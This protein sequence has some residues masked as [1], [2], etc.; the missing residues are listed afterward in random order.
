MRSSAKEAFRLEGPG[1]ARLL[2]RNLIAQLRGAFCG[3]DEAN[4]AKRSTLAAFLIR[5]MSAGIA[6]ISQILLARLMGPFEYGIFALVWVCVVIAGNLS[7]FGMQMAVIR[8]LPEYLKAGDIARLKGLLSA[9]RRFIALTSTT[10]A[11]LAGALI[12]L[13]S[14]WMQSYYV[15]PFLIGAF[16]LPMISMGDSVE[17]V[18]R[19][20]G[21]AIRA[22]MPTYIIR[23]M[24]L[25]IFML[26]AWFLGLDINGTNAL[27]CAVLATYVTTIGQLLVIG[28]LVNKTYR[29]DEA[30]KIELSKWIVVAL[31]M[32][33]VEGFFFLLV[34]ADVL[35]IGMQMNPD[36]VALYYATVKTLAIVH[37]VYFAVRAGVAHRFA[38]EINNS[39]KSALQALAVRSVVWTFWP[40]L[41]IGIVLLACGPWLLGM[42][43]PE[44]RAGY[45]LM[46]ILVVAIV[47]R[48]SIGPAESLLTMSG[49]HN[50]CASI[51]AAALATN[52]VLNLLFIPQW[53][54]YGAALATG[55][56]TLL[57]ALL[58]YVVSRRRVGVSM[59][60]FARY[61]TG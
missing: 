3:E 60:I 18:S 34:N 25:F 1:Q 56:S 26:T 12:W 46:F 59:F 61:A 47:I 6:F 43:G 7:C 4:K 33:L 36:D 11:L 14:E 17:G 40:S 48:S 29:S 51:F 13:A 16:A 45:D 30:A 54:L 53:G 39:D 32:F 42:F 52:I 20:H 15:V 2:A 21:W 57:E 27:L 9:S 50:A 35:M 5:V 58:L 10:V 23:P 37:F 19:A 28:S 31:P 38:G 49:N 55:L 8:F 44:F 41:A 22:L 24:L